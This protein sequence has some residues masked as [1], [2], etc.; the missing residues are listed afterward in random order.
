VSDYDDTDVIIKMSHFKSGTESPIFSEFRV[1]G[2]KVKSRDFVITVL[3]IAGDLTNHQP[4]EH[5][6]LSITNFKENKWNSR[7][8]LVR[9]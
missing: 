3:A 6:I 8:G 9:L 5:Q 7:R 2:L 1:R 4:L